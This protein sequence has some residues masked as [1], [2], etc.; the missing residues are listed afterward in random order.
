[1]QR[2]APMSVPPVA[3][4]RPFTVTADG[5][6]RTDDWYWIREKDN[7]EVLELL[8]AE[9]EYTETSLS[10]LAPL[11]ETLYNEYLSRIQQTDES[12][13]AKR[14]EWYYYG[15]TIEGE[16]YGVHCR[17]K[18]LDGAEEIVFDENKEA[19][20]HDFFDLGSLAISY[21]HRYMAYL[22]DYDGSERYTL[23]I[24]DLETGEELPEV[25]EDL[26]GGLAWAQDNTTLYYVRHDEALRPYQVWQHQRGSDIATDKKIFEELDQRYYMGIGT[27]RSRKYI[28]INLA[29]KT[30]TEEWLAP[31]DGSSAEF[32]CFSPRRDGVEYGIDHHIDTSGNETFYVVTNDDGAFNFKL[33]TATHPGQD[34]SEWQEVLAHRDDVKLD[35]ID[36]FRNFVVFYERANANEQI[37]IWELASDNIHTIEQPEA[38]YSASGS[39]NYEFDTDTLRYGYTSLVTPGS[40]FDYNIAARTR[41][42][43][44]QSPVLGDFSVD[45]YVSTREWAIAED[46]TK[47]PLSIV[48]HKDTKLD[49]SA[50]CLLYG[51]GSYEISIS[52]WFSHL[53]LS[54]LNRGFVFVL[55]HIRGGGEMGRLWY[56][57]GKFLTKRNTFTD[58][59][60]SSRYLLANNYTQSDRLVIRGGSAGG[61]LMGAVTN[62]APEL[63][64]GVV[65]EVPFVDVVTTMLDETIPLTV[66]EY[67]EWGNPNDK[68]Y[69]DYM[70]SYSPYD[71]VVD[72]A[73]P[74]MLVTTGLNDPRV[75]YW[76]PTKW[77]Q[78]LREHTTSGNPIYLKAEL[79]AGH[80]GPSGRYDAWR[81]EA[82]VQ[83]YICDA[84]GKAG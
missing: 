38:A 67:E 47:I 73:Y 7:P 65:A 3:E 26:H 19:V 31:A 39:A 15:R 37:R 52:P 56:E 66:G 8:K 83:A 74:T 53:R 48:Y 84:V 51:Y 49:G 36:V 70:L 40:V 79:G 10:H 6:A 57:N 41:T 24:R 25:I 60:A 33:M 68:T 4:K 32:V 30:T 45:D 81:D 11:R 35:D 62:M 22:V 46:G 54:L 17:K 34:I 20:G 13:P 29:T 27:T 12:V 75:A 80:G 76:E 77:V 5:G 72:A 28:V 69:Y 43:L 16:Q 71:N 44:K 55:A 18:G 64:R 2:L 14:D 50:P 1:M 9:N 42:L 61:L 63:F 21:D 59:I 58:F 23:R 78:K 82:F